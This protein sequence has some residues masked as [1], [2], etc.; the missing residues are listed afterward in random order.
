MGRSYFANAKD[1]E[2]E[3]KL[4]SLVIVLHIFGIILFRYRYCTTASSSGPAH[5]PEHN[6]VG[7]P[8]YLLSCF[9]E[10]LHYSIT[11]YDLLDSE[12]KVQRVRCLVYLE[13]YPLDI[14]LL[15]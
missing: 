5:F 3:K 1:Y 4:V 8:A 11:E 7:L 9:L 10:I 13:L 15:G 14:A 12:T 2:L 6:P